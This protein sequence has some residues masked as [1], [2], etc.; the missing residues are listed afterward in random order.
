[1]FSAV[2]NW[3]RLY[4]TEVDA[5]LFVVDFTHQFGRREI[6]VMN[7]YFINIEELLEAYG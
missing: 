3:Y 7:I 6:N 2:H 4:I 5:G 1:M